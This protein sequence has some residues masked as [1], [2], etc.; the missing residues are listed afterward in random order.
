M[1]EHTFPDRFVAPADFYAV[2]AERDRLREVNAD[3]VAALEK[4]AQLQRDKFET[5][6][7]ETL[8]M[9]LDNK[10]GIATT[11]ISK[12][13]ICSHRGRGGRRDGGMT[14]KW[15]ISAHEGFPCV[16]KYLLD[17]EPVTSH[18]LIS[19][20]SAID[21]RFAADWLKSTSTAAVILRENGQEVEE[22]SNAWLGP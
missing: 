12:A 13:I 15:H 22:N 16:R 6:D 20:A 17:G 3:L 1:T 7:A 9:V 10:V 18:G 4:I 5:A 19:A 2:K 21:D 11:A 8:F 14:E